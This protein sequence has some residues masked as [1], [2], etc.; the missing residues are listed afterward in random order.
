[1]VDGADVADILDARCN[2]VI[3]EFAVI[4]INFFACPACRIDDG[5]GD[6]AAAQFVHG[7]PIG[8]CFPGAGRVFV[9]RDDLRLCGDAAGKGRHALRLHVTDDGIVDFHGVVFLA[10]CLA[11]GMGIDMEGGTGLSARDDYPFDIPGDIGIICVGCAVFDAHIHT[12]V[13]FQRLATV[14]TDDVIG[15]LPFVDSRS[16]TQVDARGIGGRRREETA[17]ITAVFRHDSRSEVADRVFVVSEL[18]FIDGFG[19]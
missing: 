7:I 15:T 10:F 8:V 11:V 6:F 4:G 13:L 9:G 17:V 16:P 1:M 2:V 14:D 3:N 18:V 12:D 5:V 19:A